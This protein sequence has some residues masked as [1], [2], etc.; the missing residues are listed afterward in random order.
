[1]TTGCQS[2]GVPFTFRA[3]LTLIRFSHE[4]IEW[5]RPSWPCC[6]DQRNRVTEIR[7]QVRWIAQMARVI[8]R[9]EGQNLVKVLRRT[10]YVLKSFAASWPVRTA[11]VANTSGTVLPYR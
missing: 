2:T 6:G 11:A 10:D 8:V 1:M 3:F 7:D 5:P 4:Q 9:V